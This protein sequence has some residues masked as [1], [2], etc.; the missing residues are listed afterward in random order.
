MK[1]RR[2]SRRDLLRGASVVVAGSTLSTRVM[3]SSPPPE[4]VTQALIDAAT[5]EGQVSYYT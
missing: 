2:F 4:P 3:A 1:N 5:K